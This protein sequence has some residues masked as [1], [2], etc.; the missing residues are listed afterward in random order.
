M[1]Q[2]RNTYNKKI[3]LGGSISAGMSYYHSR[4]SGFN[5]RILGGQYAPEYPIMA[6]VIQ[7]GINSMYIIAIR[8]S[9]NFNYGKIDNDLQRKSMIGYIGMVKIP[10]MDV[11]EFYKM[12]HSMALIMAVGIE[13]NCLEKLDFGFLSDSLLE[14]MGFRLIK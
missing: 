8:G 9:Y 14:E 6:K 11:K 12:C 1:L 10:Y 4:K 5:N 7:Q 3:T 13:E 2:N